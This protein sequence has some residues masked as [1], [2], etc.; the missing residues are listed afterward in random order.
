[1]R[2]KYSAMNNSKTVF[3]ITL[4]V[5]FLVGCEQPTNSQETNQG[6]ESST[7]EAEGINADTLNAIHR[8]IQGGRYGLIDHFLV[9][10]NSKA[11]FDQSYKQDYQSIFEQYDSTNHQYNYD[12]PEWHPYYKGTS[13]HSLQSVTKS[14]TSVLVGIAMD[15]GYMPPLDSPVIKLFSDYEFDQTDVLKSSITLRDLLT[16]QGGI[17]WDEESYDNDDNDCIVMELRDDWITY[18]LDKPMDTIPGVQF[19]YNSGISVLLGKLVHLTTG[20]KID[21]WAEEKLFGPLGITDYY[22]KKT[23]RGEIDTEGGLYLS[24]HDLAKIGWL[25]L[26]DGDWQGKQVV[27]KEWVAESIA[28]SVQF[29]GQV[30]YGFQWWVPEHKEGRTSIFAGNGYGGQFVMVVPGKSLL[31]IFNGWNIHDRAEKSS[32]FALQERILPNLTK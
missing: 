24:S 25:M 17:E 31:V 27:S 29:N 28:P 3:T 21:K 19:E 23:P 12:H 26:N 10:R 11:V 20:K 8:E 2:P 6:W 16:M 1:M 5:A 7:P 15:E 4:I 18:V 32:W 22:W 30:G 14:V 9:I 13:L